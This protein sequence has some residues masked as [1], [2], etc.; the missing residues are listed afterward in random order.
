MLQVS[1]ATR[2]VPRRSGPFALA[3][4]HACR[5]GSTAQSASAFLASA[6]A[7]ARLSAWGVQLD[8]ALNEASVK[9]TAPA[10]VSEVGAV[11]TALSSAQARISSHATCTASA[12]VRP[13][14][15][16]EKMGVRVRSASVTLSI[17]AKR[18]RIGV[19]M[20]LGFR[21]EGAASV[22]RWVR[23]NVIM[24]SAARIVCPSVRE[25]HQ[26]LAVGTACVSTALHVN[27]ARAGQVKSAT[28]C[29]RAG[30]STLALGMARV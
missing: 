13:S 17:G 12:F 26:T 15:P 4:A 3:R 1:T 28:T 8:L 27:A 9:K 24:A 25:E 10:R 11:M 2:N 21:V 29:V 6:A 16:R 7:I 30:C 20:C 5:T 14:N 18:A 22:Q 19:R 23:V